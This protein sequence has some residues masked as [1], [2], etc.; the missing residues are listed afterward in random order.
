MRKHSLSTVKRNQSWN[1]RSFIHE[2]TDGVLLC[3]VGHVQII[4]KLGDAIKN[5]QTHVD[6]PFFKA[7]C[8]SQAP[9]C[10]QDTHPSEE[11]SLNI[12]KAEARS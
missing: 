10:P 12:Y 8:L 3:F 1:I 2:G 9:V 7:F 6:F 4:T 11:W 5:P